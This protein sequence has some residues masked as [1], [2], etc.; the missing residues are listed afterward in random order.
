M[1]VGDHAD[2]KSLC[3]VPP[4]IFQ[5]KNSIPPC[6]P[7]DLT[8]L[9]NICCHKNKIKGSWGDQ[10]QYYFLKWNQRHQLALPG[11]RYTDKVHPNRI[12]FEW[13]WNFF[14]ECMYLSREALLANPMARCGS[15]L[16][17]LPSYYPAAPETNICQ[18]QTCGQIHIHLTASSL[19]L[20][21]LTLPKALTHSPTTTTTTAKLTNHHHNPQT[22]SYKTPQFHF[23]PTLNIVI[24]E[25]APK[26]Q[27][28]QLMNLVK[29][30]TPHKPVSRTNHNTPL[31]TYQ[32]LQTMYTIP[33]QTT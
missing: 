24:M 23:Q 10:H 12:Y 26:Y 7:D 13:Y 30:K 15:I 25:K 4:K 19:H 21:P 9:H 32:P 17:D 2:G 16:E 29:L 33:K 8:D 11:V 14:G 27:T 1:S 22:N 5:K 18:M 28:I 31:S 6:I 3:D 20:H